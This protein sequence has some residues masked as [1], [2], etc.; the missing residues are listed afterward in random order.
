M[1][2]RFYRNWQLRS[3]AN[4]KSQAVRP[5]RTFF[6]GFGKR[7][8]NIVEIEQWVCSLDDLTGMEMH[9]LIC[10]GVEGFDYARPS[11]AEY[12]EKVGCSVGMFKRIAATLEKRGLVRKVRWYYGNGGTDVNEYR[13]DYFVGSPF[14]WGAQ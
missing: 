8:K 7:P 12:A 5:S 2:T 9:V 11:H 3:T 14:T 6:F 1:Q 10:M 13:V 4:A